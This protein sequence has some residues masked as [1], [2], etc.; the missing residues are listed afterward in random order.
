MKKGLTNIEYIIVD[1]KK[2]KLEDNKSG[3]CCKGCP[4]FRKKQCPHIGILTIC[5]D[6]TMIWKEIKE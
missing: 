5:G 3:I 6:Q 1:K 4:F 2:Y